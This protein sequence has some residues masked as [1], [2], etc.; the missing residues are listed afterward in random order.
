MWGR[1]V[2][3]RL[4]STNTDPDLQ[5]SVANP[6]ILS[7]VN[8]DVLSAAVDQYNGYAGGLK[9][10]TTARLAYHTLFASSNTI[11]IP[12]FLGLT[13]GDGEAIVQV[14]RDVVFFV[15]VVGVIISCLWFRLVRKYRIRTQVIL[16][17]LHFMETHLPFR[18]YTIEKDKNAAASNFIGVP[19]DYLI[20]LL[21]CT[22][23]FLMAVGIWAG[24]LQLGIPS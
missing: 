23:N 7:S 9:A 11:I 12:L 4:P 13:A 14:S 19:L 18:P 3:P 17:N 8:T 15:P 21:F 5:L 22:I 2:I 24:F 20:P 10:S 6:V 1:A 16:D